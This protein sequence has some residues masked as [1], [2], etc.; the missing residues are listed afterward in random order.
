MPLIMES[1]CRTLEHA[2][3]HLAKRITNNE[4]N[5]QKIYLSMIAPHEAMLSYLGENKSEKPIVVTNVSIKFEVDRD[6][7]LGR[8]VIIFNTPK[9]LMYVFKLSLN[10]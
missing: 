1:S 6:T 7:S 3:T 5:Y 8:H 10:V 4:D 9:M 2:L